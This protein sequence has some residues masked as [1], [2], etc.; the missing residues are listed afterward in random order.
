MSVLS[1][2]V[3]KGK[4][5]I[6][7]CIHLETQRVDNVEIFAAWPTE[8]LQALNQRMTVAKQKIDAVAARRQKVPAAP[9]TVRALSGTFCYIREGV[10]VVMCVYALIH[11]AGHDCAVRGEVSCL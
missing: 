11:D 7:F 2:A 3:A 6:F 4:H 8:R 10:H 5:S 1:S 9:S